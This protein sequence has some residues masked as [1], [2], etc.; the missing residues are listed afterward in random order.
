MNCAL[1]F[2]GITCYGG[3]IHLDHRYRDRS[4][5]IIAK[6][7]SNIDDT[8]QVVDIKLLFFTLS[9]LQQYN[10]KVNVST[11]FHSI[12]ASNNALPIACRI[13]LNVSVYIWSFT[14]LPRSQ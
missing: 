10:R 13:S 9:S 7:T 3:Q 12:P 14:L 1:Y 5:H 11:F 2:T 4:R 6:L 8:T